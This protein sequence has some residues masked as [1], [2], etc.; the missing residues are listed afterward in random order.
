M[1]TSRGESG[2]RAYGGRRGEP[3]DGD[4]GLHGPGDLADSSDTFMVRLDGTTVETKSGQISF[5]TND[6][7]ENRASNADSASLTGATVSITP[8][9]AAGQDVLAN[10][11]VSEGPS[12]GING[13]ESVPPNNQINGAIQAIAVDPTNPDIMYV[14]SVNGGI[15]KTTNATAATPH[16]VPLTDNLPSLSIGALEFDPTDPT[17]QTLIAG[18]GATSSYRIHD[19]A[20]SGILRTTDGG[21]TWSQLGSATADLGGEDITSVAARGTTLLAAADNAW[22][23]Q[24]PGLGK[25]LFRS[26]DSGATWTLI[27]D[28]AHGLPNS[29]SVSNIAGD[30]L[31]SNVLYAAVIGANGGI[32]KSTDTGLTWT[33]ITSGIGI[34]NSTTEKIQL[35]VH[36][37]ATNLD[38][39]ATVN[40]TDANGNVVLSGVFRSVNSGNFVALDV[41][42]GGVQGDVHGAIAADPTN[43]NIVYVGYGGGGANYLTRIDASKPSGSQIT[44]ISGGSF[45]S[46]HVDTRDM[47]IDANG[48]LI[49][50]S[51]GGL[52]RLPT[53]AGNTGVWSAIVGDISVVEVHSIAYDDISHTIMVGTQDNGTLFQQTPGSATWTLAGGG[54]GG[55]VVVDDVSLAASG[56]SIRYFSSQFLAGWTRQVYDSANHLVSTTNLSVAPAPGVDPDDNLGDSPITDGSFT[57]PVELNKVDPTRLLVGGTGHIYQSL[58]QGTTLTPIANV[59]VNGIGFNGGGVMVYG[60]FQNGVA[61]ADLIYAASGANVLRQT[62]SGGGFTAT[63][64]GGSTIRGVTDNPTNWTAVF[65]IDD[66]Q[67][68]ESTNAGATWVDVTANLASISAADFRSIEYV[69]GSLDDALV[70]GTSS[71]VFYAHVSGLGGA[72]SWSKFGS[73]LPDV[74]VYDLEYDATD[75][76]L[77]AGTMGRGAWQVNNATANLGIDNQAPVLNAADGSLSYTENQAATAIDTVLTASDADSADLVSATVSITANFAAGQDVLGFTNQNGITGSYN[78]ATGVLSLSGASSVASYQAALR[79]V[80]YFNSSDNPSTAT[81]TISYQVDDG[82]AANHA[83]NVVTAT[84]AVTAV[85]PIAAWTYAACAKNSSISADA[86]HGVLAGATDDDGH[87]ALKVTSV[88]LLGTSTLVGVSTGQPAIVKG[89]Y[90]TLTL[91]ADG[92]YTYAANGSSGALPAQIVPQDIFSYVLQDPTGNT[93]T[94]D[95]TITLHGPGRTYAQAGTATTLTAGNGQWALDGGDSNHTLVGGPGP[96][97]FLAGRGNDT[98]IGGAG[99]DIFAFGPQIGNDV[100]TNFNPSKDSIQ[101]NSALLA[102]YAAVMGAETFN[103]HATIITAGTNK[104]LTL[105][106]V[107]PSNLSASNFHFV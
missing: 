2:V 64:P 31:S 78:S 21:A 45:G 23:V 94:A 42:S 46:P 28:G 57:T 27:S 41:P 44:D 50:S 52:F 87:G 89:T 84:V 49:L 68:F 93:T 59:G 19:T 12:P 39:F 53:P 100:I 76:V 70:V 10:F 75:N 47:Q 35:A 7:G 25:G 86:A 26:T 5:T 60:G 102:N 58:D 14:G 101:F 88:Q 66:N 92:S 71:G 97:W 67:V 20:F 16:W 32:F 61:D 37:D 99:P 73:N 74:I 98:L 17:H 95:L 24:D 6:S 65:T 48:N 54:D 34:I 13:Q 3:R 9:F 105:E 51:D 104:T 91:D 11:W 85:A 81:R 55:D 83:S 4:D 82:A 1:S 96:D 69:H 56:E 72:P 36:H 106:N 43:P 79:S 77:V 38:V 8:N 80:T 90:G 30:P 18:I 40:N 62:A 29:Q 22:A 103:G 63:S 107:A 33:N 15:W